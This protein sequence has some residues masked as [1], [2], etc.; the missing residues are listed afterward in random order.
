LTSYED[1]ADWWDSI[2]DELISCAMPPSESGVMLA[3]DERQRILM[4]IRCGFP[5]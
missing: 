3:N 4:W 5:N 2:R 1:V